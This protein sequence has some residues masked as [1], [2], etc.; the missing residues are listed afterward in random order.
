M[1]AIE[2]ELINLIEVTLGIIPNF[3]ITVSVRGEKMKN[4]KKLRK[5]L[6]KSTNFIYNN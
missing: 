2:V 1:L 5:Y 3:H 4:I 6:I